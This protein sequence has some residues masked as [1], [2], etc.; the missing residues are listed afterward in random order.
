MARFLLGVT[1]SLSPDSVTRLKPAR[2]QGLS[3]QP[4]D[5]EGRD[6]TDP[7]WGVKKQYVQ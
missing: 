1:E 3:P 4:L 7:S 2:H 5:D 6:F